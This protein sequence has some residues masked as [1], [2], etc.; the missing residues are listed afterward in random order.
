MTRADAGPLTIGRPGYAGL[1][2]TEF[3]FTAPVKATGQRKD[4]LK[5]VRLR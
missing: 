1:S 2:L 4:S 5:C 3:G